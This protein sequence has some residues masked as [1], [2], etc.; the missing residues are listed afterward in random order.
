MLNRHL[1]WFGQ[2]RL[3]AIT[4]Q[5][6]DRYTTAKTRERAAIERQRAEAAAR[7]E[8]FSER[9][10]SNGTINATV[11]MLAAILEPAVEYGLLETNP[12]SGRR[13]R[14]KAT[15]PARPWVE[16]EQLMSLLDAVEGTGGLLLTILAGG[17][18]RIGEAL[19]LRWQHADLGTGTLHVVDAKTP[20]GIREVHLS[21]AL[22]EALTLARADREMDPAGFVVATSTGTKHN[23]SNPPPRRARPGGH[24]G[25]R[26][27]R[28]A[29]DR[30]DRAPDVPLATQDVREPPLRLR[31]RRPLRG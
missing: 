23:P 24:G 30:P 22:R 9:P 4:V 19:A 2:H 17:G 11:R 20:K 1:R 5:E 12:A 15:R 26:A 18:L 25:E 3:D 28:G 7:G 29:R 14:L 16:P 8:R 10:L 6:V 21:P 31:R 13:R 27:A